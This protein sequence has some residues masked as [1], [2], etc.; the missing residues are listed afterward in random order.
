MTQRS[1]IDANRA[2]AVKICK[3]IDPN[4]SKKGN[5]CDEYPFASTAEGAAKKGSR[6]SARPLNSEQNQAAGRAINPFFVG[7]RVLD[8]DAF[9]VAITR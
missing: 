3:G 2:A 5:D 9:K 6:F 1:K 8:G 7:S 4:Y